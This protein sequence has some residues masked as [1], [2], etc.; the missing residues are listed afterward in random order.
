MVPPRKQITDRR[1][2]IHAVR[3]QLYHKDTFD[4]THRFPR[5]KAVANA[6]FQKHTE[7]KKD[8]LPGGKLWDP[9]DATK[10]ILSQLKPHNDSSESILGYNDWL[11]TALPNLSQQ[12]LSALI[13]VTYKTVD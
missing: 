11:S 5:V 2:T 3:A 4:Q 12:T 8:Q 9:D 1:S 13:E 7:Y 6:M 10:A